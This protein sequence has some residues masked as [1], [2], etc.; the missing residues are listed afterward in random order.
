MIVNTRCKI[1]RVTTFDGEHVDESII[2]N[3]VDS[4]YESIHSYLLKNLLLICGV[5]LAVYLLVELLVTN[6]KK[7]I[8]I[9]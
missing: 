1:V 4:S 9:D 7:A 3:A 6:C 5:V 8:E 2:L